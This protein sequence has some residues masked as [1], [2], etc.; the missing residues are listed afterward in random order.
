[1]TSS[2]IKKVAIMPRVGKSNIGPICTELL[3]WLSEH[4]MEAIMPMSDACAVGL[5]RVGVAEDKAV[6]EADLIV[7]LGGDGTILRAV[8]LLRGKEIPIL[9]VNL[10][11]FG[12]MA[13]VETSQLLDSMAR[14]AVGDFKLE[15]RMML[16]CKIVSQDQELRQKALNEIFV[17][18]GSIQRLMEFKVAIGSEDFGPISCDGLILASPTG[19]TAYALSAGGPLVC[20]DTEVLILA[21][22][23]PHSLFNRSLI[24][25]Q[26]ETIEIAAEDCLSKVSIAVDGIDIWSNRPVD[27]VRVTSAQE[28]VNL[29]KLGGRSFYSIVREKLNIFR[30]VD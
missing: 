13:E 8:R 14:I 23:C 2:K 16:D 6:Q 4:D 5:E 11:T 30:S 20:P 26:G 27:Y 25:N 17:G 19:S 10:G 3:N 28:K 9:G 1:M 15:K 7:V 24:L 12:F 18:R 22:V 21:A 29:V